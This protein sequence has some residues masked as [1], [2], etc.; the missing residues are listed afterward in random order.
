MIPPQELLNH[1]TAVPFEPFRLHTAS[2]RTFD[3]PHPEFIQVGI[4]TLTIFTPAE[5]DPTGAQ[6]WEKVSLVL[7]ESI[8]PLESRV[9]RQEAR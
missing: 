6:R 2:G 1:I 4:S 8:A 5:N 3:V 9:R 7:I